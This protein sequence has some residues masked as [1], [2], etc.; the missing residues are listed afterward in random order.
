[1]KQTPLKSTPLI[2]APELAGIIGAD[3][4]TINNWVQRGII[5]RTPLGGRQL[6]ARLFSTEEVYKA[7]LTNELVKLGIP[8]SPANEA[9]NALWKAWGNKD[10]PEGW[11]VYALML[12]SNDK[13]SVE[14]CARKISGGPLYRLEKSM[15][16]KS[17]VEMELPKQAFAMIPI[18]DVFDRVSNKLYEVLGE[19]KNQRG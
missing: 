9:V 17:I 7:A 4:E 16:R 1:M 18:S 6:R 10:A 2:T 14:L 19:L 8:P 13:W 11:N 5:S 15:G 3:L 12:P